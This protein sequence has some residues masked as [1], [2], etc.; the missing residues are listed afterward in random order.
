MK[1]LVVDDEKNIVEILS[2]ILDEENFYV[3]KAY[4]FKEA[5]EKKENYDLVFIDI[6]LPD[7]SGLD[8]IPIIRSKSADTQIVMITAF[9]D[10]KTAVE[11]IKKGALDY[12]TKP[13]EV[14]DIK[15]IINKVK[16]KLIVEKK[17]L[18][19]EETKDII[20]GVSKQVK[21]IREAVRKVAPYDINVLITGESGTGK[22]VLAKA[23]HD[24]SPR[25]DKPFIAVNCAAIPQDLLESELFGY[26]KGAFTG[27]DKD[28]KGLIEEADRGTLFLDEIGEMPLSLQAKLLRFLE[29]RKIRPLGSTKEIEVDVRVISATNRDLK[30]EI[31]KGNF[32][33]DLYYRLSTITLYIPPL[34]ERKEDIPYL[35][36][37]LLQELNKKYGKNIQ[38]IDPEFLTYLKTLE[39]KGN[40]RELRN[41][42]EK[43]VILAEDNTLRLNEFF[44][45]STINS[46]FVDD[47]NKEFHIKTF[48]ETGV[49]LKT[50]MDS[51]EKAIILYAYEKNDKI[52]TKAA[53]FLGLTF[54]EFRY[55]FDKFLNN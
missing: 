43:S 29:E 44:E 35:V 55:R 6:R 51:I 2:F 18:S 52:K 26:K 16:S 32:R 31:E 48:P 45:L 50:L 12:I 22:E 36:E 25:K 39:L 14:A 23:I 19:E 15:N 40:I 17:L 37:D 3:D 13:F 54:R 5:L 20:T 21:T 47:I 4:S 34:R 33:E 1:A 8:L 30:K 41:I 46:I 53:E 49:N 42:L 24:I 11:A 28:K 7:G 10:T 27:A 9:A 38:K